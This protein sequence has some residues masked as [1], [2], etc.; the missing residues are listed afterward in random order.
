MRFFLYI[1]VFS[2]IVVYAT[3]KKWHGPVEQCDG[4]NFFRKRMIVETQC[5][6]VQVFLFKDYRY[7]INESVPFLSQAVWQIYDQVGAR[8]F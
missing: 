8:S 4:Q 7:D 2:K 6:M 1:G 5:K 3:G